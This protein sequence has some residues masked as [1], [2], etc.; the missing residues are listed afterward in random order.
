MARPEATV[1]VDVVYAL[2]ED[3]TVRRI[4]LPAGATVREAVERST[5][6]ERHPEL[7][8]AHLAVGI[9][10]ERCALET[11]VRDG[12]RVEIYRRLTADPK[13][14]RRRRTTK[15]AGAR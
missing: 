6:L 12:D 9:H 3:Q 11:P 10:G 15:R 1:A 7:D 8:L 13:E 14:S 2:T 4:E 5:L